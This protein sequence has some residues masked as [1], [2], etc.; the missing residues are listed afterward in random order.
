LIEKEWIHTLATIGDEDV[1]FE[2]YIQAGQR[3]ADELRTQHVSIF[4]SSIILL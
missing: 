3:L 4:C 1:I 2:S